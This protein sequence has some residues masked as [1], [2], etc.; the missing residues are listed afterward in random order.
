[1]VH[2]MECPNVVE[3]R[4]SLDRWVQM[5][6]DREVSGDFHSAL[7]ISI[8]NRPGVLAQVAA[9]IA[10]AESN[11]DGVEYMAR[12]SN[13]ASIRFAIE[14]RDR[15]HIADVIRRVRRLNVVHSVQRL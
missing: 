11:I 2:R 1:V 15:K 6:W 7:L 10:Q 9:A 12:D 8:E 14:V 3:Y 13:V 5:G 4:K